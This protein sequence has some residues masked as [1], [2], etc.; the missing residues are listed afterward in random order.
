[1]RT[2]LFTGIIA[3]FTFIAFISVV[4]AAA[5]DVIT[6]KGGKKGEVKLAHKAHSGYDGVS[7]KDCHHKMKG[8]SP[9]KKCKDC[10]KA[11]K[12]GKTPS[13]KNAMH[14]NC[15]DCHKKAKKAGKKHGPT[16]KCNDCHKKK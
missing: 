4:Y 16:A 2:K 14:K 1:M 7:C 13:L 9:K 11:K 3:A 5:A 8:K 6:L 12:E 15:K 10:H